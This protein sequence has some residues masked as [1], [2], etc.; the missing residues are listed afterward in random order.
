MINVQPYIDELEDFKKTLNWVLSG[1]GKTGLKISD[2][3]YIDTKWVEKHYNTTFICNHLEV[4]DIGY[5]V[6]CGDTPDHLFV[7][8][9]DAYCTGCKRMVY[10]TTTIDG[11]PLK[12][13]NN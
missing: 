10:G 3:K 6:T 11:K 4:E 9:Y 5:V 12:R 13:W 1:L 7:R 2:V 8:K